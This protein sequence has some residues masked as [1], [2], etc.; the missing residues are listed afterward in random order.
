M[1][2]HRSRLRGGHPG[3]LLGMSIVALGFYP[4]TRTERCDHL[5]SLSRYAVRTYFRRYGRCRAENPFRGMPT[6]ASTF[7]VRSAFRRQVPFASSLLALRTR[8]GGRHWSLG[9]AAAVQLPTR[10]H[11]HR[12]E[13]GLRADRLF[14]GASQATRRLS[15]STVVWTSEHDHRSPDSVTCCVQQAVRV[16]DIAAREGD[17]SRIRRAQG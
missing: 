7:E 4:A 2:R 12:C 9:L 10:V 11:P 1:T 6:K 17:K 3:F 16:M 15:T 5:H 8:L 14:T 13:L